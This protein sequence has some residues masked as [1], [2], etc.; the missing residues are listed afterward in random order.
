[1]GWALEERGGKPLHQHGGAWQGFKSQLSRFIGD[2]L[3]IIVLANLAEADPSRFADG[4]A[5]IM[6]PAL[7]VT[8][9][10][11][12]ED[13]EPQVAARLGRLLDTIRDGKLSAAEFA[14]VR[15]GFFPD[16]AKAYEQMLKRLGA[17]RGMR[18]VERRELGDDRI[19]IYEA[20]Y[21]SGVYLVRLGLAPD[22][23]VSVFSL[24][25][26]PK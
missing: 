9:P 24:R 21:A 11:P 3:S 6:N 2:D 20:T 10:A 13:R 15:A 23:R 16:A 5:A 4:I 25:A 7:A 17:L 26:K 1:M 18:L 22:D 14:Y 8:E 12:I 19:Y